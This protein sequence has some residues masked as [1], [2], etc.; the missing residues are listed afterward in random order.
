MT[1]ERWV[2]LG[3]LHAVPML[4]AFLYGFFVAVLLVLRGPLR[5]G[6]LVLGLLFPVGGLVALRWV[7]RRDETLEARAKSHEGTVVAAER[8]TKADVGYSSEYI[9]Y[10]DITVEYTVDGQRYSTSTF[11]PNGT[12]V[13]Y[14]PDGVEAVLA[15]YQPGEATT[16]Y[17]NPEAPFEAYLEPNPGY[18]RLRHYRL[19]Y[20][21]VVAVGCVGICWTL[22]GGAV[23]LG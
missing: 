14:T 7:R 2:M 12:K 10:P 5:V 6:P 17:V 11:L 23:A 8:A 15:E 21:L 3:N 1:G 18:R 19:G 9:C 20:W 4:G 16:V 22:V 13:R